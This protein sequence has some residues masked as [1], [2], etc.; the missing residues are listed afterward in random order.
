MAE[1]IIK[2]AESNI[3]FGQINWGEWF[4]YNGLVYIKTNFEDRE[5][6]AYCVRGQFFE[7]FKDN[8][9]CEPIKSDNIHIE[10]ERE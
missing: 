7:T 4:L 2:K 8:L 5:Y 9:P 10:I 6:N 1:V 3:T